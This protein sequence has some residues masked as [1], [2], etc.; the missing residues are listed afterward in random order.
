TPL[1]YTAILLYRP[2][3]LANPR[4][5]LAQ[6]LALALGVGLAAIA[7]TAVL[8]RLLPPMIVGAR[9]TDL[10]LWLQA[11]PFLV[12]AFAAVVYRKGRCPERRIEIS[13]IAGLLLITVETMMFMFMRARY[14]GF[15]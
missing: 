1:L 10:N 4:R 7:V 14:D 15:W 9:F 3:P 12:V 13:V 8:A 11:A 2:R 5:S 6:T